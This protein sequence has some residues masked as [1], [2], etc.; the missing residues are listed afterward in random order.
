MRV[1]RALVCAPLMPEFDRES[2]SKRIYDTIGFLRDAG[3]AVSFIAESAVGGE[4]HERLL[5]QQGVATYRGFGGRTEQLIQAAGFDLAI[6]AFWYLAESHLPTIR[7]LSPGTR[8]VVDT[9]DLHFLRNARRLSRAS[10]RPGSGLDEK[11]GDEMTREVNTYAAADGVLAVSEKEAALIND[12]VGDASL[13]L[14]APDGEDLGR[15]PVPFEERTGI[16]FLGN[17]RHPPNVEAVEYF[18]R[19]IV[20]LIPEQVCDQHPVYIVGNGLNDTILRYGEGLRNVRMV[21][22]VPSVVPYLERSRITVIP[23]RHGAGTKRKLVQALMAGTPT[24]STTVGIEGLGLNDGEH[25]VVADSPDAF[26]RS[27][28]QLVRDRRLWDRLATQGRSHI[29]REHSREAA[30]QRLSRAV[31]IVLAK[32][33]KEIAESRVEPAARGRLTATQYRRLGKRIQEVVER[34]VPLEGTVIVVSRGDEQLVNFEGRKGWHFPQNGDGVYAGFYPAD[35][36][37]AIAHLEALR[38]KGGEYLLL[39]STAFWWLEHYRGLKEHLERRY[40]VAFQ[41]EGACILYNLGESPGSG[42]R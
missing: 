37:T 25:L 35:S 16:L 17:F 28:E 5:R 4:R 6:F 20:P 22:W 15:S 29:E 2:G 27:I 8:I 34:T 14:V 12:L 42:R 26:A 3:W 38:A 7:E 9:I 11:F 1:R 40:R 21:G 24:V 39:P 10:R 18:C 32:A 30:R 41:E 33:P 19:E 31:E 23:L 13:A 36:A